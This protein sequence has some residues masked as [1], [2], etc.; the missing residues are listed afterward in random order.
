[1]KVWE[2]ARYLIEAKKDVDSIIFMRD[3][4]FQI[5]EEIRY[6]YVSRIR[7]HFFINICDVIDDY[8]KIDKLNKKELCKNNSIIDMLYYERDKNSAHADERYRLKTYE[9]LD[10]MISEMKQQMKLVRKI[11]KE[12]LPEKLT[13]NYVSHDKVL[14][15]LLNGVDY[16]KEEELKDLKHTKRR[17]GI[18]YFTKN[19]V[20][21]KKIITDI[22]QIRGLTEQEKSE[23]AIIVNA[24]INACEGL[25]NRQ[26]FAIQVNIAYNQNMWVVLNEKDIDN[27]DFLKNTG[28][29]DQ[30]DIPRVVKVYSNEL[31]AKVNKMIENGDF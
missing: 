17:E 7:D 12:V 19:E 31:I 26:D 3:N 28:V 9:T 24:G 1:M 5:S 20:E 14:F 30:F 22:K 6:E 15:R 29:L 21:S 18:A 13:L 8:I 11:C 4:L 2:N 10:E 25:Q 27:Y 23:Y 16:K